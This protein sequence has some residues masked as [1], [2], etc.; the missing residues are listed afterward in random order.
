MEVHLVSRVFSHTLAYRTFSSPNNLHIR[1][2]F[3]F[4]NLFIVFMT[5]KSNNVRMTKRGRPKRGWQLEGPPQAKGFMAFTS[6]S[7][8]WRVTLVRHWWACSDSKKVEQ[9]TSR[10]YTCVRNSFFKVHNFTLKILSFKEPH[11]SGSH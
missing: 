8:G 9:R 3:H 7:Q 1:K 2:L 10:W 5:I 11:A 6:A 4:H